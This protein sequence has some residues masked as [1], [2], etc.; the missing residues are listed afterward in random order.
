MKK[1]ILVY[2]VLFCTTITSAQNPKWTEPN[3]W[4]LQ[5]QQY[6]TAVQVQAILGDP[7]DREISAIA[8]Q[9]YYQQGP[10]RV[11]GK[12]TER[13]TLGVVK[14][15]MVKINPITNRCGAYSAEACP[16]CLLRRFE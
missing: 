4:K 11:N 3:A 2:I 14:F 8:L 15:K 1:V 16:R 13:P 9:W 10:T 12:V 7:I 6:M 5:L